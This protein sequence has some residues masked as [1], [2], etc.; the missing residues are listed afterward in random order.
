M[1]TDR[2]DG[3]ETSGWHGGIH[4]FERTVM[5]KQ[6][7]PASAT[8]VFF[9]ALMIAALGVPGWGQLSSTGTIN[10]TVVDASGA[11]IPNAEVTIVDLD[12]GV[13]TVAHTNS[14]GSFVAP[15]LRVG[16][17]SVEVSKA[18]FQTFTETGILL[19]PATV[20]TVNVTMRVG[21][22]STRVTVAASAAQVQTTSSEVSS[23]VSE[24]QVVTLPLNG[25]NYQSLSALMP[26]VTNLSPDT[27]LNQGGFLTSNVI[28]VN[29]MG[30]S[31]TLFTVDGI[32]DMNTGNFSQTT[33]TPNPDTIQEARV[34]QNN[35]SVEYN[36]FGA[37]VMMIHT[38]SGSD[39]YHGAAF[40]YLRNDAL[41]ARN[42]F[43]PTV[44]PL[45]QNIFGYTLGGPLYIP[46]HY[47]TKKQKTFFFWSQQWTR[48]DI[49]SNQV[50]ATPT[51]AMR[52]GAFPTSDPFASTIKN[53]ATGQPFANNT[54]PSSMLNPNS[55]AVLNAMAS[56]PNNP[57][58]GFDNFLN[59]TPV[60]ND[61]R[62][63]EIKVNQNITKK[64]RLTA[65]YL[66][67]RQASN[68]PYNNYTG[69]PFPTSTTVYL[70]QNQ[71]A[72]LQ[73]TTMISS[74]M[75]NTAGI[76]MNNYVVSPEV[77]G[78]WL[79]SQVPAFKEALPFSGFLSERLPQIN[80]SQGWPTLGD[81]T[82]YPLFH[83]SDL[84]DSF[85]DN[86]SLLRGHHFFQSGLNLV[87]GTKRQNSFAASNGLW[88]FTGQF[89]GNA[90]A[91][92]LIGDAASFSQTSS[93]PRFY[94]H[95]RIVS[96]YFQD[97]WRARR[98][99]TLTAGI[100]VSY[101]P[102]GH[103]QKGYAGIFD[104]S[105]YVLSQA[106]V[107]NTNGTITPTAS[108][109]PLN[110]LIYNGVN[111]VPLNFTTVHQWYWGP[112]VGFAWD[113][114][115]NGKT[116]LRGGYGIAYQ[117]SP[118]QA[119]C[120]NGC[121]VNPPLIKSVNLV[122]PSFPNPIGA[123]EKPLAAPSLNSQ[124]ENVQYS[125]VQTYSLSLQ[126]QFAGN[127][128][129]SV[130]GA[131]NIV[132]HGNG[133]ENINQPLPDAPYDFNPI[134]NTGTVF[135]NLYSPYLGYAGI[136]SDTSGFNAYWN[137]LEVDVRHPVGHNLFLSVAYTWEHGLTE[138]R[139]YA[140]FNNA[141]TTQDVYNPG[142]DYGTSNLTP[143]QIFTVSAI[144]SLP[145]YRNAAGLKRLALSGWQYSDITTIQDGFPL[146]PG[147]SVAHQGL[148]TRP[149]RVGSAITGPQTVAE[150]F[151]TGAFA[152]PLP[153]Y[154]GNAAPGSIYG[155]GVV[156]FDMAFYKDFRIKERHTF[157]FRAEL[158]NIF[159]RANFSG[160]QTTFGAG[161]FGR[162]TS[163]R[164]PRIVEFA[165]RYQF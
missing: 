131:G 40:E 69:A 140:L 124:A 162:I 135:N 141:S 29:G 21:R 105:T 142:L 112:S 117:A 25:R 51:P 77:A 45:K 149:N 125:Q 30:N 46:H 118:I 19:H 103:D 146:D 106:P 33:I 164:D 138:T 127:W 92:F 4:N 139:G 119:F 56:L 110:G 3:T 32:W 129:G 62:D 99:L 71:L 74:S 134:I 59:L 98:R 153:G 7:I 137:A 83:A 102:A 157:Q 31:G 10:G 1:A 97:S 78:I 79:Q 13:S 11:V 93:E 15:A 50:G 67:D 133:I 150:W 66:D 101:M 37:N 82:G 43:T 48:Q 126:H 116:A 26:G 155:P 12:T 148:A 136:P 53:P 154:F 113:V 85:V 49:G 156:D 27:A 104:P 87:L 95:Y 68:Q 64:W 100:R 36:L 57:A 6:T 147:L 75:V 52:N 17:Y 120:L 160:V 84:E 9:L 80:L 72:Q 163:A 143:P 165:L 60:I 14:R 44:P 39:T 123:A 94:A 22:V 91:D 24:H 89:T 159:N 96:P 81:S 73:L 8:R 18:G 20:A 111:G 158:F 55:L 86:W 128:F 65:E 121:A 47:N 16:R 115:G 63:D 144:W 54:I 41:N 130:T 76:S 122:T 34:L 23:V 5:I 161:N 28:S 114:F 70:T 88:S 38:R 35:Y 90:L 132:R 151:N 61:T 145:W 152:A 58:G 109:N 107:V 2:P 42:F 108:Y